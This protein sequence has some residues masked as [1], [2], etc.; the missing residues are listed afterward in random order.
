MGIFGRFSD[1]FW[2]VFFHNGNRLMLMAI[3][4]PI[5]ASVVAAIIF[6]S[7]S[8]ERRDPHFA[9][10]RLDPPVTKPLEVLN[11]VDGV[12]GSAVRL[13]ELVRLK[14]TGSRLCNDAKHAVTIQINY[15]L[16]GTDALGRF[17]QIPALV[18]PIELTVEP[19]CA[20]PS[21]RTE[22]QVSLPAE[23]GIGT[24]TIEISLKVQEDGN[25]QSLGYVST[26]F[27]T[28]EAVAE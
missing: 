22:T 24:W 9:P 19:G 21:G 25:E 28:V 3:V 8:G 13:G 15:G 18:T 2:N 7:V 1:W 27:K 23:V 17:K 4:L 5:V 14:T 6:L 26:Q 20:P 12:E 16:I 10:I 11:T